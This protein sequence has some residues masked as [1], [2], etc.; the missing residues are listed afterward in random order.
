MGLNF[1][2]R[3]KKHKVVA[4]IHRGHE[5]ELHRFYKEHDACRNGDRYAV[6][7]QADEQ[8]EETWMSDP[9]SIG[10]T[11]LGTLPAEEPER[12]KLYTPVF[13]GK[14]FA[15]ER[16]ILY[17]HRRDLSLHIVRPDGEFWALSPNSKVHL[18]NEMV[19]DKIFLSIESPEWTGSAKGCRA[20]LI[21]TEPR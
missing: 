4:G 10:Y 6:E 5:N 13:S 11:D 14:T 21:A 7:V 18:I 2:V 15:A 8:S 9:E 17:Q 1:Y 3:C 20:D 19:L 12:P 16:V